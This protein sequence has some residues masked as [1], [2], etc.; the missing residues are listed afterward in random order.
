MPHSVNVTGVILA[1]GRSTRFGGAAPKQLHAIDG[2]PLVRRTART[3]LAS[4]LRQILVVTGHR[5]AE[6]E[7]V[8]AGLA[9]EIAENRDFASGQSTS[10]RRGLD[11]VAPDA[12]AALFIPCD[13]PDLDAATLDRILDTYAATGGPIVVPAYRGHR[14]APV[15]FD[16]ALFGDLAAITGDR[17][18]RQLF[19]THPDAIVELE[20]ASSTPVRDLD[21]A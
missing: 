17:G 2:E 12:D 20:L 7:A 21:R 6:I 16:R 10:V 1:A 15:L 8:L 19:A 3:A 13:L 4:R 5:A 9:V 18:G 11:A 14:F